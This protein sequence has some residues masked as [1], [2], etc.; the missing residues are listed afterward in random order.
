MNILDLVAIYKIV[1]CLIA[2]KI[3][4]FSSTYIKKG[5]SFL[6]SQYL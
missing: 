2:L 3:E 4:I 1:I 6:I 5:D